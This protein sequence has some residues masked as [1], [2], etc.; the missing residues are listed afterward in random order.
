MLILPVTGTHFQANFALLFKKMIDPWILLQDK[1]RG[2]G[3]SE[4]ILTDFFP[5]QWTAGSGR[6]LI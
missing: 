4:P 2:F 3:I 1:S 5:A 6:G